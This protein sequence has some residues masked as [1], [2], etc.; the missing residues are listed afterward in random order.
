MIGKMANY[1]PHKIKLPKRQIICLEK[2]LFISGVHTNKGFWIFVA[3]GRNGLWPYV[4]LLNNQPT[5]SK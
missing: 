2:H 3:F 1:H 4:H 5:H